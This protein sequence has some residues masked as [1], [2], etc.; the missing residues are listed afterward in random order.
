MPDS[1][2]NELSYMSRTNRALARLHFG[3]RLDGSNIFNPTNLDLICQGVHED[4]SR[5]FEEPKYTF[6]HLIDSNSGY[7]ADICQNIYSEQE[8]LSKEEF[9]ASFLEIITSS[10]D[11][12]K[13]FKLSHDIEQM[14]PEQKER[15]TD[16]LQGLCVR[17]QIPADDVF[18]MFGIYALQCSKET[19]IIGVNDDFSCS[20][21]EKKD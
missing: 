17:Y 7:L 10:S 2:N 9:L 21:V 4:P 3:G 11:P 16:Y 18:T 1:G 14:E 5:P 6:G 13:K 8:T 12:E 19:G 15:M 20:L